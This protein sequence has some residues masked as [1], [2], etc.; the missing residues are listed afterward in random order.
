MLHGLDAAVAAAA[1]RC[2]RRR[3]RRTDVCSSAGG[4][5]RLAVVG[6]EQLVTAEAGHR[7]GLSAGARVVH[8]AAG[9]L[10]RAGVA[11]LRAARPDVVLLVGGTDGGDAEVLRHNAAPAGRGPAAGCRWWWPATS[12]PA[13][14]RSRTLTGGGA[15]GGRRDNVLPRIGVL[16]PG[17]G[18]GRDPRGVPAPRHRR[19]GAVPRAAVRLA[20][21]RRRRRTWC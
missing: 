8:V 10:D 15:A 2:P 7:V 4:G 3:D 21:A 6:Y 18:P 12:T 11:A 5:L 17:A 9:P 16:E 20:G 14:T 19:Q 13:T 1:A